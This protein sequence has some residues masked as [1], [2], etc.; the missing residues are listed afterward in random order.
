MTAVNAAPVL[1]TE[2]ELD[3]F[4]EGY[5]N[6]TLWPVLH[7][8]INQARFRGSAW[9][10]AYQEVNQRFAE[11]VLAVAKDGDTIWIHDY[12]LFLL[13][14]L[15]RRANRKFRIGFF[16]HTPFPSSETFR[17]LPERSALL[18]GLL[19][20]DLI[21]FHTY[22]YL[23]HFRS[24][25]LRV[26]GVE[27]E[28]DTV[29]HE[30]RALRLGVYPIGHDRPGFEKARRSA[31]FRRALDAYDQEIGQRSLI[32]SVERLDYT[33]GVLEKLRAIRDFL[34]HNPE[35]RNQVLFLLI[36]VPSRKGVK[37]FDELTK[38]VQREVG[39]IN[40][41]YSS[42]G[43]S[44]VQFLHRGLPQAKVA[45]LYALAD[46]CLVLPLID[47]MNLVAKEFVDGKRNA[48]GE[49]P[50]CLILSEFAGAAQD[51]S[52]AL[53]VNPYDVA[54]VSGAI[55]TELEMSVS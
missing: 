44:P 28:V 1:L 51:M 5:S 24:S 46:V 36:A 15:I 50:G 38:R 11:A 18:S 17:T 41:E 40:G 29:W 39:A 55:T 2:A 21:G 12:H 23:R 37:A 43:H 14:D 4:Y 19:G 27:S 7:N 32:L 35:R 3:G 10:P 47:G 30:G 16:L 45:A 9:F 8:Q 52:H 13:P 26:L 31:T 54:A 20:A 33:K 53:L 48:K 22:N 49:R 34:A 25:V 42:V 6:A